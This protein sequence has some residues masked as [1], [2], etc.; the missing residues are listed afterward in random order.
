MSLDISYSGGVF[1]AP[2][3]KS[4]G[5]VTAGT[6]TYN[7]A[8]S[9]YD[10]VSHSTG[11]GNAPT[12]VTFKSDGTKMFVSEF[13]AGIYEY[14]LTTAFD[15]STAGSV[16]A[17]LSLSDSQGVTFKPDGTLVYVPF[18]SDEVRKY[19]LSTP[20]DL[21]TAGSSTTHSISTGSSDLLRGFVFNSDGSKAYT[22]SSPTNGL[23]SIKEFPLS[24]NY[25]LPT[26]GSATTA[27]VNLDAMDLL[28]NSIGTS[29]F[30][31]IGNN[32]GS[33]AS[34]V[35]EYSLSTAYDISTLSASPVSAYSVASQE[36]DPH[37]IAFNSNGSKMYIVGTGNDTIFQYSTGTATTLDLSTG[38]YF[39]HTPS[40]NTTFAFSNAPASGTAAGFALALTGANVGE[41]YDL[42]NASYDSVSFSVASQE[43]VP[44]NIGF[45]D[46]GTS[47]YIIGSVTDAIYQYTL[48]TAWDLSTASYASKSLSISGETTPRDFTFN[49]DGTKIYYVGS[50]TDTVYQY[51]L[52]TAYDIS[53]AST[54]NK[55]L[56]VGSQAGTPTGIEFK[57]DG[58]KLYVCDGGT[59][60]IYQYSLSTAF[61]VSTGS[62]DSV[63][64]S[65]SNQG[66]NT[67]SIF[68]TPNGT[69]LFVCDTANDAVYKYSLSTAWDVSTL[70]YANES[71]SLAGQD[72]PF[73]VAF[74]S[75]GSKMY[76]VGVTSDTV[77]QYTTGSTATATFT[78]PSSVKFPNGIA[79]AGPAIGET[80]VLVFYTDDGGT[81]YQGFQ[82]GDAMA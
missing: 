32:G 72:D 76:M 47:M 19:P 58:T 53:T 56:Y 46:D 28:F 70:S 5:T 51:S 25:D 34:H 63:S 22:V 81:T 21:S 41:T 59:D 12:G 6:G 31:T 80:D 75:D 62:Y 44:N 60:T 18:S 9:S 3:A 16:D 78:Y 82:A 38:N 48:S 77:Y 39:S 66:T 79:P 50:G 61:D 8:V 57:S 26:A 1:S 7:L 29:L 23:S 55:S 33:Y 65:F 17:T 35:L 10:G 67:Q 11:I 45:N 20:W 43:T 42:A 40:A 37:G 15:V 13:G 2:Q 71:F 27:S 14:S 36:T 69:S 64:F 73:G 54:D 74:K 68:F 30:V 4:V 49:N 24:T 52:S